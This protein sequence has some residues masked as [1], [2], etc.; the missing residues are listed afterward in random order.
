MSAAGIYVLERIHEMQVFLQ[1]NDVNSAKRT[2]AA[3]EKS[4]DKYYEVSSMFFV[5]VFVCLWVFSTSVCVTILGLM[6][7]AE[8]QEK[9]QQ[10]LETACAELNALKAN[11]TYTADIALGNLVTCFLFLVYM[12][13]KSWQR[14]CL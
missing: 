9:R 8:K 5:C 13:R 12:H 4:Y 3:F 7:S 1:Q 2:K 14:G 6:L 10:E 11:L